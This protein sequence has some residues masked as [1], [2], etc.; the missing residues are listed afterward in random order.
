MSLNTKL[1]CIMCIGCAFIAYQAKQ[2]FNI[3]LKHKF[4]TEAITPPPYCEDA[5]CMKQH[6]ITFKPLRYEGPPL[7]HTV[8]ALNFAT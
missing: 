7:T 8:N 3:K 6:N 5:L 4:S 2:I 1:C